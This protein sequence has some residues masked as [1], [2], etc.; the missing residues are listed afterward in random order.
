[1]PDWR[2]HIRRRL[3]SAHL[4]PLSEAGIVEEIAQHL[5]D[6]YREFLESGLPEE[7]CLRR[8]LA[9]LGSHDRLASATRRAR[10]TPPLAPTPGIPIPRSHYMSVFSKDLRLAV[11]NL[12]T[13]P[14]FSAMV[15]SMLALGIAGNAAVFSI[16]NALFLKPLPFDA[17]DRLVEID[18]TAPKWNLQYVGVSNPDSYAWRTGNSTFENMAYFTGA[19]YNLSYGTAVQR[20]QGSQVTRDML[21]VFQLRPELGRDFRPE[22]DRPGGA[23]V[24][25]LGYKLWQQLFQGDR[26]VLG[27]IVQL[28]EEPYTVIGVLPRAAVFP[29]GAELWTPLA[30][31]PEVPSG[32][33]LNGL[34]R[35]K[36]G[37]SIRQAQA[38][39]LRIHKSRVLS[40][41][42]VNEITSPTLAPLRDRYLADIKMVSGVLLIAVVIVLLIACT[43]IAALT[44]VRGSARAR[45]IAIR[46]AMGAS[47]GRLAAQLLTENL[48]L[49][50]IGGSVG[51]ALGA[52]GVRALVTHLPDQIPKWISFSLDWRFAI[53]CVAVTGAAAL[54]FG[55]V[56]IFQA[57]RISIRESLQNSAA[58]TTG[59]RNRRFTITT[60]LAA[61]IALAFLLSVSAG[62]LVQ[63]F[64]NVLRVD[65]GFRPDNVLTFG[66]SLPDNHYA[67]PEQKITYYDHLLAQLGNLAGMRAAGATSSP[68]L[69]GHWGGQFEAEQ[70]RIYPK[71]ENPVVLRIAVTPGYFDAIGMTLVAGRVFTPQDERRESRH[72]V[73]VNETFVKHFWG[74]RNAVGRR[75]RY[76]GIPD[77]YD[78][79]G[80]V[81]D[82]RHDGL[83]QPP[84]P[85]VFIPY[86]TALF[87]T[88]KDDLRALRLMRIVLRSSMDPE[89]LI[90]PA[91]EIVRQLDPEVPMYGVTT[92]QQGLDKSLW[93]RRA[94]SW[95]FGV[96]A[97]I[98][99]LLALAGVYGMVSYAVTQQTRE[100]GIR[101]ALGAAPAQ[102]LRQILLL[103][104]LHV[105]IGIAAGLGVAL[106]AT[107]LLRGMLFGVAAQDPAIFV[108]VAAGM[109]CIGLLANL[110][111]ALR[112]SLVDPMR[113]LRSE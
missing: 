63:A 93:S 36:S 51:V 73:V 84:T 96:F 40:G 41:R 45:E 94:Y 29:N 13:Q 57:S 65:P 31:D 85:T 38:D 108:L 98:A 18:E 15:I 111:P 6:R 9:E 43:N 95:T 16:F 90:T 81:R 19:S 91:R 78:V 64:N 79:V 70:G 35:L 20:V 104:M 52:L 61:E 76:P 92:L 17:S 54:L 32:Y 105:S 72:V 14:W 28:D 5:D 1:M 21:D 66:I 97:A 58:R 49:A 53:F 48:V 88:G 80:L 87:T 60:L 39:L 100:I 34:G 7:E 42:K 55:M 11:R 30:V 8:T 3:A 25:L 69:G 47:R 83:D 113:A 62:L 89:M 10:R 67:R 37:V 99:I 110:T 74:T 106:W 109:V 82:E 75:I 12:R 103:G 46:V 86:S 26:S 24:V 4:D 44:M 23:K 33:Y 22:E 102:V 112:A 71:G 59:T 77:W 101:M 50:S 2:D 68:P 107:R 56:P 27:R